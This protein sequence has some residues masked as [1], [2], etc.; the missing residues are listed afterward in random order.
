[1]PC[2][3]RG[4]LVDVGAHRETVSSPHVHVRSG[5]GGRGRR[6]HRARAARHRDA[7]R[8]DEGRHDDGLAAHVDLRRAGARSHVLL[9]AEAREARRAAHRV[10]I[11]YRGCGAGRAAGAGRWAGRRLHPERDRYGVRG[12]RER[13]DDTDRGDR[14]RVR[15]SER[16]GRPERLRPALRPASRDVR[17]VQAI[18]RHP[19]AHRADTRSGLVDRDHARRAGGA[20][21]V[22]QLRDPARRGSVRRRFCAVARGDL[23]GQARADHQ[24]LLRHARHQSGHHRRR[25]GHLQQARRRDARRV[26]RRRLVRLGLL[27]LRLGRLRRCGPADRRRTV[28]PC[29]AQHRRRRRRHR[30]E[31]DQRRCACV[32]ERVERQRPGRRVRRQLRVPVRC[33]GQRMQHE[34][35]AATVAVA[36]GATTAPW[37]AAR[38]AA[39]STSPPMPTR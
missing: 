9:R 39:A 21:P 37:A 29:V 5:G 38:S 36:R 8:R 6:T 25:Q 1:M 24:Q 23:R 10:V 35:G 12:E 22:P 7:G 2:C 20:R 34:V 3:P 13:C 16:P 19:H 11:S 18:L 32:G 17:I 33:R 15:R 27:E 4:R 14:G 28:L 26:R 31:A 30:A